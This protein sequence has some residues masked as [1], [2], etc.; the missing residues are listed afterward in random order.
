MGAF[1][2]DGTI[3]DTDGDAFTDYKE[4]IADTDPTDPGDVFCV[5]AISNDSPVTA[6]QQKSCCPCIQ[7]LYLSY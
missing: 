5:M 2:Y 1:E 4:W 7:G 3:T 6:R